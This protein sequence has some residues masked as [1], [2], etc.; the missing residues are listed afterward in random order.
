[1]PPKR[2]NYLVK[3]DEVVHTLYRRV[4]IKRKGR[5]ASI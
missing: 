4:F 1:M 5:R 3:D 2:G